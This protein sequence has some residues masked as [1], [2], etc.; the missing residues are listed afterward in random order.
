MSIILSFKLKFRSAIQTIFRSVFKKPVN[1][2]R[3][4]GPKQKTGLNF[5]QKAGK[6]NSYT[7]I[8][9]VKLFIE[10][11]DGQPYSPSDMFAFSK[12]VE[13]GKDKIRCKELDIQRWEDEGGSQKGDYYEEV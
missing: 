6:D 9:N 7:T 4:S 8:Y 11:T 13:F 10:R 1:L 2:K 5:V 3:F 12:H